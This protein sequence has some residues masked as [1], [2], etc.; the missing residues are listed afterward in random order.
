MKFQE[1]H[2]KSLEN[3]NSFLTPS[4]QLTLS[5]LILSPLFLPL[6]LVYGLSW[7]IFAINILLAV[8]FVLFSLTDFFDGFFARKYNQ[9]SLVGALLDPIADKFLVYSTLIALLAAHKIYFYWV[10]L[11]VGRELL[12]MSLRLVAVEHGF[13][14]PVSWWGKS[15]TFLQ[16]VLL[17]YLIVN[18]YQALGLS[19]DGLYCNAVEWLLLCATLVVS[20]YS[21]YRYYNNFIVAYHEHVRRSDSEG[22][23]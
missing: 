12:V 17:T 14:I 13:S 15:K 21:A 8:I 9:E 19:G 5:R 1:S 6:A 20:L 3:N 23:A 4:M 7:N 10:V 22:K 11:L 18:P 2:E 16:M